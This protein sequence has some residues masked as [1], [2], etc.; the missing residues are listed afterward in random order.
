MSEQNSNLF[1][2]D[3]FVDSSLPRLRGS[4]KDTS[5]IPREQA[6]L[7][8]SPGFRGLL[9]NSLLTSLPG[10][11]FARLLP[12]L[13]PVSLSAKQ[14][15]YKSGQRPDFVY[16]PETAVFSQLFIL[17]DG[18]S[19][20]AAIIGN[21][22]LLGLCG[23]LDEQVPVYWT[24][25]IIPGTAVKVRLDVMRQEF[26]SGQAMQKLLLRYINTR[27]VHLAQRAVCNGRHTLTERLCTWLLMV[28][29]RS[30]ESPLPLT[31]EEIAAHLGARRAGITSACNVLRDGN[32]IGYRRGQITIPE[33][34]RLQTAACECY[35]ALRLANGAPRTRM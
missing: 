32:I 2:A 27:M 5:G 22:G 24:Q 34:E 7:E 30:G 29:D 14:E 33:R 18:S 28:W 10:P 35:R 1:A 23:I 12:H 25:V 3:H 31:H 16:F 6:G 17:E 19:M 13:A 26:F 20:S 15:V 9:T 21:E 4:A 8:D 11:E